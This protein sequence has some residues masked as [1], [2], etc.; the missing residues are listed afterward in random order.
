M[1]NIQRGEVYD[2]IPDPSVGKEI[3][4]KRPCVV[5]S[6]NTLNAFSGLS[7]VCPITE[8]KG[9]EADII[10]IAIQKGEGGSTKESLVLCDQVKAVDD[11]RLM[12]KRGNLKAETMHRI[13]NGLRQVLNL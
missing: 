10:H 2:V 7:I 9:K 12:E 6:S 13:D 3:Q 11:A 8:G 5:V 4:K 1:S